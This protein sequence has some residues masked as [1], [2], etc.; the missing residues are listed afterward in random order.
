MTPAERII[1]AAQR[2]VDACDAPSYEEAYGDLP[3]ALGLPDT[4]YLGN[5]AVS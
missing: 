3:D 1:E 2:L 4:A 5:G